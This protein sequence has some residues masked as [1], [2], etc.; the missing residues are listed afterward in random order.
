MRSAEVILAR[1]LETGSESYWDLGYA[2]GV[3]FG[4]IIKGVLIAACL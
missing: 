1:G 4:T 2:S 3:I